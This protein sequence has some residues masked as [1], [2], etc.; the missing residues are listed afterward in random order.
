MLVI[1]RVLLAFKHLNLWK[2]SEFDPGRM[3]SEVPKSTAIRDWPWSS[4]ILVALFFVWLGYVSLI[5]QNRPT[6]SGDQAL[7]FDYWW[8]FFD[9][10][11]HGQL[12]QWNPYSMLGRI[13]VQW[14]HIPLSI[15]SAPLLF[16]ELKIED[17]P[18]YTAAGMLASYLGIYAAGRIAGYGRL[19]AILPPVVLV[20]CGFYRYAASFP[21][22]AA[23]LAIFPIAMALLV[24]GS[25][26]GKTPSFAK[27]I[28]VSVLLAI[29]FCGQRLE[30]VVYSATFACIAVIGLA[31]SRARQERLRCFL[32][33]LAAL[34]LGIL[35][36][37]WQFNILA[38][39]LHETHRL[40]LG[41]VQSGVDALLFKWTIFSLLYQP[42]ILVAVTAAVLLVAC[43]IRGV[44]KQTA[45]RWFTPILILTLCL[46]VRLLSD[47]LKRFGPQSPN[48]F[49]MP[50]I[51]FEALLSWEGIIALT[52][53][54]TGCH[55]L[56][57]RSTIY[58][59]IAAVVVACLSVNAATYSWFYMPLNQPHTYYLSPQLAAFMAIGAVGLLLSG[60]AWIIGVLITYHLIGETLGPFLWQGFSTP[61]N[62]P[63]AALAEVGFQVVLMLETCRF[64]WAIL[65]SARAYLP[66]VLPSRVSRLA[67]GLGAFLWVAT[68]GW[69]FK[70]FAL[71]IIIDTTLAAKPDLTFRI[72]EPARGALQDWVET[73]AG[74]KIPRGFGFFQQDHAGQLRHTR[75]PS[76]QD[77][78]LVR[79]E[80]NNV[81][82]R[83]FMV[84]EGDDLSPFRGRLLRFS[85]LARDVKGH[86][87]RL[88]LDVQD[89][90]G[91]RMAD[92]QSDAQNR[93]YTSPVS[94]ISR[95]ARFL[96]L[97]MNIV[98][99]PG[100]QGSELELGDLQV[101]IS[102]PV[103]PKK[104]RAYAGYVPFGTAPVTG[105]DF[106]KDWMVQAAATSRALRP[107]PG[108][109]PDRSQ[110]VA[111]SDDVAKDLFDPQLSSYRFFPA[112]SR[113][114]NTAPAYASEL[115]KALFDILKPS[116]AR[117]QSNPPHSE[118]AP[119][120]LLLWAEENH[121][122]DI[123]HGEQYTSDLLI[124]SHRDG[125]VVAHQILA[126]KGTGVRRAFL[127]GPVKV[128][129]NLRAERESLKHRIEQGSKLQD[130]TTTS[131]P[132]FPQADATR[133]GRGEARFIV[134]NPEH[135]VIAVK[136]DAPGHLVLLDLLTP[137]WRATLNGA[138]TP[139]YRAYMGTR[140]VGVPAGPSIV[141]FRYSVPGLIPAAGFSL[142]AWTLLGIGALLVL[143]GWY[144]PPQ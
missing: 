95:Q 36:N 5:F 62:L 66:A 138:P 29:A 137:G 41:S 17:F 25:E 133:A 43:R 99:R 129:A 59:M 82:L 94:F 18:Y 98:P 96:Y 16:F 19:I 136:A 46:A 114:Y 42:G 142:A 51:H 131:D 32:L 33:G 134:D 2:N 31:L 79:T 56:R 100:D 139:I 85:V 28:G 24:R 80:K 60:R 70:H 120:T 93:R 37:A 63:R 88:Q 76:G 105:Y 74:S 75:G 67:M 118:S 110:R 143:L 53:A 108:I 101:E 116:P 127:G 15:F 44:D 90:T 126:E 9:R 81:I 65:A 97:T 140:M 57:R 86:R 26:N 89:G 73:S 8:Y 111:I 128:F 20:S 1:S 52:I 121:R 6:L 22:F 34:A 109:R 130:T 69:G 7:T 3:N 106:R 123:F 35:A 11:R 125:D 23:C 45:P 13:A 115:P 104:L 83:Y 40:S 102:A 39:S 132:A 10:L 144:R 91:V 71:P 103:D 68:A 124:M 55:L 14:N 117:T 64:L 78:A 72:Y 92:Y 107:N 61:W 27:W 50:R 84:R 112:Y 119:M 135:V 48:P 58:Q 87:P 38:E 141:E 47:A 4:R 54:L 122:M 30:Q 113:V 21:H 77:A 49:A 12:A